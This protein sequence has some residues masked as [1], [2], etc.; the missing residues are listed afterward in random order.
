MQRY[1]FNVY[2]I[3][4]WLNGEHRLPDDDMDDII[5]LMYYHGLKDHY[6]SMSLWSYKYYEVDDNFWQEYRTTDWVMEI[7]NEG[8][9]IFGYAIYSHF[10]YIFS[11]VRFGKN[12][13][14][15]IIRM[16][17]NDNVF[18]IDVKRV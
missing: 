14:T 1:V 8:L 5:F 13:L 3:K 7:V 2:M 6:K 17:V 16:W 18:E 12:K 10:D 15:N 4:K 11:D 9:D